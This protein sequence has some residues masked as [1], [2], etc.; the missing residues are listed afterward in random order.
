MQEN[1]KKIVL[2]NTISNYGYTIVRFFTSIIITR[3]LYLGLGEVSYGFWALI[4][5]IFGYSL[6]LDFGFG[7]SVQKYTAEV[8]VTGE[9]DHFNRQLSTVF[10]T[11]GIMSLVIILATVVLQFFIGGLFHFPEGADVAYYQRIFLFFGVGVALTFPTGA[12]TEVLKGLK[13]IYIRN[14]INLINQ[15]LNFAG[16][17][18]IFKMGYGLLTLAIFSVA[19]QLLSNLAMAAFSFRF[20]TKLRLS[21]AYFRFELLKEIVSF[22]FFAYLIMFAN[23]IIYKTDQIVV[24]AMLGVT[25]VAIYQVG[26]RLANVMSQFTNQFQDNLGPIAASLYRSGEHGRLKYILLHSN[27]IITFIAVLVFFIFTILARPILYLWLEV[28]DPVIIQICYLMNISVLI[29]TVFRSG[30]V[31]TLLMTGSHKM[32]SAVA[33]IES[34]AN[35]GLSILFIYLWGVVGVALGT[36]VPN[37]ILSLFVI[38]PAACRFSGLSIWASL[39]KIILPML[40]NAIVPSALLLYTIHQIPLEAWTLAKLALWSVL[41]GII[42]LATGWLFVL[43]AAE[44]KKARDIVRRKLKK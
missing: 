44:R 2:I 42:F 5:S 18:I 23:I 10:V 31:K 20:L 21:F 4:W 13:K 9:H 15:L 30:N 19:L 28:T 12:F 27:R 7:T 38:Y 14:S 41:A 25:S 6:L 3:I 11:Y 17:W 32:L 1:L 43:D 16:I 35:I 39:R 36:L 24:G 22:S 34:V 8:S 37:I 26:S 29:L 40:L 33:V